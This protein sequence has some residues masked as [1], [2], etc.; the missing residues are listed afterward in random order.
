MAMKPDLAHLEGLARLSKELGRLDAH[1]F[2]TVPAGSLSPAGDVIVVGSTGVFLLAVWPA[3]GA[4]A[5]H[6]GRPVVGDHSIPGL[7]DLRS[8]AKRLSEKLSASSV[9]QPVEPIVCLTHGV[10][11]MPRDVKG[12]HVVTLSDLI[13]DLVSR[14]RALEQ[15]RVQRAARVLGVEIAGDAKRLYL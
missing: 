9:V 5:V 7:R 4:F 2:W 8:D 1:S 14:P 12:I 6:R 10:A 11:G 3:S 15:M 13:K